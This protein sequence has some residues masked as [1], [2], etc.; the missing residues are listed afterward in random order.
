MKIRSSLYGQNDSGFQLHDS[1][2]HAERTLHQQGLAH[3]SKHVRQS[4]SWMVF[5]WLNRQTTKRMAAPEKHVR[6]SSGRAAFFVAAIVQFAYN[7]DL[8]GSPT[9]AR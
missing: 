6:S 1:Q 2:F 9:S 4:S 3:E 8:N 5:P 7:T